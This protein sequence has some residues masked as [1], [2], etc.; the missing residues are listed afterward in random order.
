[1]PRQPKLS[2]SSHE[3]VLNTLRKN[4]RP[5]SAYAILEKL[6]K[7][8]VKSPPIVYRALNALIESGKVHKINE[9]NTFVACDCDDNHRH[10]LSVLTICQSCKKVSELHDHSVINHLTKLMSFDIGI[11]KQAVIELPI[12]CKDCTIGIKKPARLRA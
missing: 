6:H 4:I 9:L 2:A 8:G 3:L 1:M 5:L 10:S 11:V 7:F 12:R